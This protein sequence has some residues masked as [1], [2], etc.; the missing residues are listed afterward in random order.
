MA[1]AAYQHIAD[2]GIGAEKLSASAVAPLVAAARGYESVTPAGLKDAAT[3]LR[4]GALNGRAGMQFKSIVGQ[5]GALMLPW[6]CP[7]TARRA[8][9]GAVPCPPSRSSA[10]STREPTRTPAGSSSTSSW[11]APRPP[12]TCTRP[13]RPGGWTTRPP[14]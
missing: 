11:P 5:N 1:A 6:H 4:V 7:A 10:R 9:P 12:W 14:R 8:S 13:P 2:D 3:R